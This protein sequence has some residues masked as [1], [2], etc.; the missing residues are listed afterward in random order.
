MR[1]LLSIS[2]I[3]VGFF[4]LIIG[5]YVYIW[6][7]TNGCTQFT[8]NGTDCLRVGFINSRNDKIIKKSIE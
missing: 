7:D 4:C 5:G 3:M 1:K 8:C 6:W 2:R